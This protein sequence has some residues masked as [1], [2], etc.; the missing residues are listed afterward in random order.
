MMMGWGATTISSGLTFFSTIQ[1]S[2]SKLCT[3]V[4][5]QAIVRWHGSVFV[6]VTVTTIQP[7]L[8]YIF[9]FKSMLRSQVNL[10]C[11]GFPRT[12]W[13]T[14]HVGPFSALQKRKKTVTQE[15]WGITQPK[16]SSLFAYTQQTES[17]QAKLTT[18]ILT[19]IPREILG[20]G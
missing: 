18:P 1:I 11:E 4:T 5:P 10:V 16:F 19:A 20:S 3:A 17:C 2:P 9:T 8:S 14:M 15:R 13:R 12:G 6:K 7:G